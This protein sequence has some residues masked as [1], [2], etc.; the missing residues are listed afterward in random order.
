MCLARVEFAGDEEEQRA[1][2]LSDVAWIEATPAGIRVTD[3]S[4]N[5]TD[6]AADIRSIDFMSSVVQVEERGATGSA[7]FESA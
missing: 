1:G 5:V 7:G 6:L 4:G 3:L 2:S